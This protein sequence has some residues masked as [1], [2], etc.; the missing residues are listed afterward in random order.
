MATEV[1]QPLIAPAEHRGDQANGAFEVVV[2]MIEQPGY[3]PRERL[4]VAIGALQHGEGRAR[5]ARVQVGGALLD[6]GRGAEP[7]VS[8]TVTSHTP[9]PA[10][11]Q[12]RA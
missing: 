8:I 9:R 10:R 7:Q 5:G 6:V 12:S 2:E 4:V 3:V 11:C 1:T